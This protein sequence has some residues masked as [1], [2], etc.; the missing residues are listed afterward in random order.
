MNLEEKNARIEEIANLL[1]DP[2]I[3]TKEALKLFEEGVKLIKES[4]EY[5]KA[6]K[7][8]IVE[9]KKELDSFTEIKFDDLHN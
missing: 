3:E 6:S 9:L 5:I 1:S 7:E 2:K 4:Y 8:K